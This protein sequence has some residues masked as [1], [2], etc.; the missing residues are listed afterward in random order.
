MRTGRPWCGALTTLVGL[1]AI[2]VLLPRAG[3][4]RLD[5]PPVRTWAALADWYEGAGAEVAA[6]AVVRLVALALTGWLLIAAVLQVVTA[7]PGLDPLRTVADLI[8]P[9]S[10]QRLGR[11]L[12][13][14]SLTA[15]LTAPAPGAGISGALVPAAVPTTWDHSDP[16]LPP[17]PPAVPSWPAAP[18]GPTGTATMHLVPASP[19]AEVAPAEVARPSSP[20]AAEVDSVTVEAGD[21]LWS[22]AADELAQGDGRRPSEREVADYWHLLIDTNRSRLVD[23]ANPDLIYPG[24]VLRLPAR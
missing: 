5:I 16:P 3:G 22:I 23:P 17:A 18:V 7:L 14:L 6:I 1:V 19:S 15:A 2:L 21:S 24:Q 12:A 20:R 13:G 8:S 9:R 11:S 4:H 10:L